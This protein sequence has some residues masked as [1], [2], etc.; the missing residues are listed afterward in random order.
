MFG[1]ALL[2]VATGLVLVYIIFSLIITSAK[3]TIE[4]FIKTRSKDLEKGIAE[5]FRSLSGGASPNLSKF[6]DHPVIAALYRGANYAS[7][8]EANDL[9]SY[10]PSSNFSAA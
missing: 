7:A 8:K 9:P 5:I 3:E 10:I 4:A 6:Y 1:S 2:G